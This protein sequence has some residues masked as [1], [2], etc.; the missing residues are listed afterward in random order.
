M[1][2]LSKFKTLLR[3]DEAAK[4]LERLIGEP[5]SVEDLVSLHERDWFPAFR[6]CFSELV[7]L[8]PILPEEEHLQHVRDGRLF[9]KPGES[10]T[11]ICGGFYYPYSEAYVD[12]QRVF[13]LHGEGGEVYAMRQFESQEFLSSR[14][15]VEDEPEIHQLLIEPKDIY[16]LAELA[17][18]DKLDHKKPSLL[19]E[20]QLA[21]TSDT[22]LYNFPPDTESPRREKPSI[23]NY[24]ESRQPSLLLAMSALLELVMDGNTKK[25]TQERVISEIRESYPEWR[26]SQSTLQ[27]LFAAANNAARE[28]GRPAKTAK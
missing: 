10:E 4:L 11:R 1:S 15:T 17:N 26:L 9:M 2:K 25:R 22:A 21:V 13:A 28:Q 8:T 18:N 12:G 19:R 6:T 3:F 23:E 24:T 14:P 7:R 5:V 20:A 16:F 27:K